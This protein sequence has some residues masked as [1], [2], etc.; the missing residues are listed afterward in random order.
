MDFMEI[1][2]KACILKNLELIE[3]GKMFFALMPK[4]F[5]KNL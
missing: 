4:I 5:F 2:L 1:K 3:D